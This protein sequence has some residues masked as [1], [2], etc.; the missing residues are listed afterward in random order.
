MKRVS[1]MVGLIAAG[2]L[3][4]AEANTRDG[5]ALVQ[6]VSG[7]AKF[8]VDGDKWLP[9]Q[10]GQLLKTGAVVKTGAKARADLF[11]GI[12]GSLLRLDA[13]TELKFNRLAIKVSPIEHMAET[14][15]ELRSGRVIGNVRKLPMGSSYVLNTP[16]G[17][18][19]VKGTVY[20]INADG[21]LIVVSG[22][23]NYTDNATGKEVLIASG[24]KYVGGRELKAA[25]DE[26]AESAASAPT[27]A[28]GFP[29]FTISVPLRQ[30]V[31][32]TQP[33]DP[34][35]FISPTPTF[36][37]DLVVRA[38]SEFAPDRLEIVLDAATGSELAVGQEL[39]PSDLNLNIGG[40]A[41]NDDDA[42]IVVEEAPGG[43]KK[44]VVKSKTGAP[45]AAADVAGANAVPVAVNIPTSGGNAVS[46]DVDLVAPMK[47]PSLVA[48]VDDTG[49]AK[50]INVISDG[51]T[52][53]EADTYIAGIEEQFGNLDNFEINGQTLSADEVDVITNVVP[54]GD[55]STPFRVEVVI[56]P[57][58]PDADLGTV[59]TVSFQ[60]PPVAVV[61]GAPPPP[62][63]AVVPP[64]P[65]VIS[66][67]DG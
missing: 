41:I 31:W 16:K 42:I 34:T 29:G 44:L 9:L 17:V 12:N 59:D 61:P 50:S 53:D 13:N 62:P 10:T 45:F 24:E 32:E 57:K 18:A 52:A 43:G 66:P 1:F 58:D 56:K 28:P 64:T 51:F 21:E 4:S 49:A 2:L 11:L 60:P 54:T 30:G 22:K 8:S 67:I 7:E 55:E 14:E 40:G 39:N 6:T 65:P 46:V 15:M 20:D 19:D 63:P 48:N 47:P 27:N 3:S 36:F 37:G 35:Q 26:K 23:V 25:D 33:I 5:Q 38:G